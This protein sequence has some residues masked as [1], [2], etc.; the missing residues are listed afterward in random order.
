MVSLTSF[1]CWSQTQGWEPNFSLLLGDFRQGLF[2]SLSLMIL[3]S[4]IEYGRWLRDS[5]CEVLG[6]VDMSSI[7]VDYSNSYDNHLKSLEVSGARWA[8][9]DV[10][11]VT[12]SKCV[13][14]RVPVEDLAWMTGSREALTASCPGAP[15]PKLCPGWLLSGMGDSFLS[16][17]IW[18]LS[19]CKPAPDGSS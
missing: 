1:I 2:T 7:T 4:R 6:L 10:G 9:V 16:T 18:R 17:G 13:P 19:T 15:W 3:F 12:G 14:R 5:E 11:G 8:L